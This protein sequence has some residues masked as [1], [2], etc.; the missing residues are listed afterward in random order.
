MALMAATMAVVFCAGAAA[1]RINFTKVS[2]SVVDTRLELEAADDAGRLANLKQAFQQA[3]CKDENLV[4]QQV[5]GSELPNLVCTL[6]GTEDTVVVVGAHYDARN[7]D[8][9]VVDNWSGASLLPSLYEGLNKAE[10]K[11]SFVFVG[12]AAKEN[13]KKGSKSYVNGLSDE[14]RKNTRAMVNLD[15]L[16]MAPTKVW[17][18]DSNKNLTGLLAGVGQAT[19]IEVMGSNVPQM[20]EGDAESFNKAK[21]P[22]VTV[23]S[24]TTENYQVR[25]GK[26]DN[27]DAINRDDYY[28]SYS[29]LTAYLA[30]L[31]I[32]L[33]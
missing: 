7:A 14:Q 20:G 1:Q 33:K 13:G 8:R 9:A 10:R 11:H 19:K 24:A 12:F 27:L 16:G 22:N 3:G 5:E 6:P 4:E 28:N 30:Y 18:K 29:L 31:D 17:V 26:N 2:Q 25:H 32:K 23:H 15:S 21:I